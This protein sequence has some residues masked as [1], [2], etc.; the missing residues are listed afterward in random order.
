M[1]LAPFN[2]MA[3]PKELATEFF[4]I[5]TRCEYAMKEAGYRRDDG[6]GNA[7]AAWQRLP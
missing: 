1:L 5:F 6:N 3:V 2:N 4:A 7:A